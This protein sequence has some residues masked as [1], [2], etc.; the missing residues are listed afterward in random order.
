MP[1]SA[2]HLPSSKDQLCSVPKEGAE[3]STKRNSDYRPACES[4]CQG[5][6]TCN[7]WSLFVIW[8]KN[9]TYFLSPAYPA[10]FPAHLTL[11]LITI[12]FPC[13]IL[14]FIGLLKW[15]CQVIW[16]PAGYVEHF[17]SFP[18]HSLLCCFSIVRMTDLIRVKEK[19]NVNMDP[20]SFSHFQHFC[21]SLG[22]WMA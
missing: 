8:T 4:A 18:W 22:W 5:G 6:G 11:L 16:K 3:P 9:E 7:H 20:I 17:T 2:G 21:L 1:G 12:P 10:F 14:Q 13:V 19:K 15:K